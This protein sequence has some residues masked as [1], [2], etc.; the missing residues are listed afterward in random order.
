MRSNTIDKYLKLLETLSKRKRIKN[1][2]TVL[3][4]LKISRAAGKTMRDL[5]YV[6]EK[7]SNGNKP[8]SYKWI[9]GTPNQLMAEAM[10]DSMNAVISEY[11]KNKKTTSVKK[12]ISDTTTITSIKP[13]GT[14][15]TDKFIKSLVSERDELYTH[16]DNHQTR[17]QNIDLAIEAATKVK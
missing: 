14:T 13:T 3:K 11:A 15:I 9:G 8:G 5:G 2:T 6:S 4:K 10:L 16:I 1:M 12:K 7:V 17:I